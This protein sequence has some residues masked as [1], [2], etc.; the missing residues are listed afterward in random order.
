ML[1][2]F[3]RGADECLFLTQ[4][5]YFPDLAILLQV[6]ETDILK[7][8][9]PTR[10]KMWRQRRDM[11]LLKGN[12]IQEKKNEIRVR[13]SAKHVNALLIVCH[14]CAYSRAPNLSYCEVDVFQN[15][16]K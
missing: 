14:N 3:P 5:N 1:E 6:D 9:L 15:G 12:K 13:L 7:R 10:V 4:N 11:R 16:M 8:L 2:G